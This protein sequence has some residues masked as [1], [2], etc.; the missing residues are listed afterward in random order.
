MKKLR[1]LFGGSK[2]IT[3]AVINTLLTIAFLIGLFFLKADMIY[4]LCT[5]IM[6]LLFLTTTFI[7]LQS[8]KASLDVDQTKDP[9]LSSITLDFIYKLHM[10]I[11][12]CDE[13]GKILW[14]N[15][16]LSTLIKMEM[17]LY[18]KNIAE[19]GDGAITIDRLLNVLNE[20]GL[21]ITLGDAEFIVKGY[22]VSASGKSFV[23]IIW[24]DRT[25]LNAVVREAHLRDSVLAYIV[26]DNIEAMSSDSEKGQDSYRSASAAIS[27]ILRDWAGKSKGIIREYERDRYIFVFERREL[28]RFIEMKFDIL[29]K[30]RALSSED[31]NDTPFT[32]SMGVA[33]ID[34]SLLEKEA[35]ARGALDLALQ[36]GG[37]QVVVK[38]Y[39][40][41]EFYGGRTK[42]VQKRTKIRSRVV[43]NTLVNM[44]KESGRVIVMGHKYV[45]QD[46]VG[47]SVGV[48]RLAMSLGI[49]VNIVV[50][51][52]DV[53]LKGIFNSLRGVHAYRD[54]FIDVATGLDSITSDTLLVIT[55]VNNP[56][57]FES[58]EIYENCGVVA[59][60]DHHRKTGD[61]TKEPQI[62]YIEPSASSASELVTEILEQ[63]LNPGALES[64]EAE[65]LLAGIL[66]DTKQFSRNTGVRTFSAALY[67]R[68]CGA[69]PANSVALFK[70]TLTDF[71]REANFETN[72][73]IYRDIIAISAY[74]G[75][76]AN[77]DKI[78]AAKVADKLLNIEGV[79]ASFAVCKI[80]DVVHISA[81]SSGT[82]NVQL[83]LESFGGGGHFDVAGAQAKGASV[84]DVLTKLRV[85]IDRYLNDN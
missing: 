67:L 20:D 68:D 77:E 30:V 39:Q 4:Y 63:S 42:T 35:V 34:G 62:A 38:T 57:Y 51:V 81:R 44:M 3:L 15:R 26:V 54:I 78:A 65:V 13:N 27:S 33:N 29:D 24:E 80:G 61:F 21:F 23:V 58:K 25:Q 73:K 52:H 40:A 36:R 12:L 85:C 53:N 64:E 6:Y 82:V 56:M 74:D 31:A 76:A 19:I 32:V 22:K 71:T 10:P 66:L 72:V 60:I 41:V 28:V 49:K 17:N 47:A 18:D 37:D 11:V 14:Y 1:D 43:A 5:G 83:I 48:A 50:N 59:I 84:K 69:N 55:D 9:V 2:T 7:L 8:N 79:L 75:E 70:T 45:D 16:F 46:S